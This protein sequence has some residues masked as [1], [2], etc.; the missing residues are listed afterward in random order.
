[1]TIGNGCVVGVGMIVKGRE[2]SNNT[3]LYIQ[4]NMVQERHS[5]SA[6]QV[7]VCGVVFFTQI[8]IYCMYYNEQTKVCEIV[9]KSIHVHKYC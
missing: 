3:Q 8:Q 9:H 1:M 4:D 2:L 6:P 7:S 5:K